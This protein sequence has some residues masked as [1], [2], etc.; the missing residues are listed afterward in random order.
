MQFLHIL[1]FLFLW[2]QRR[3]SGPLAFFMI[4]LAGYGFL[5]T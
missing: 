4:C 5:F 1:I 3:M 2:R